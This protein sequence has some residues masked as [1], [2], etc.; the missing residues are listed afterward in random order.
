[1]VIAGLMAEGG[2]PNGTGTGGSGKN[3]DD[4]VNDI[5]D[6][7]GVVSMARANDT[8]SADSEFCIC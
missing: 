8:D 1:M 2:D 4:E 7:R 5:K 3:L 6:E